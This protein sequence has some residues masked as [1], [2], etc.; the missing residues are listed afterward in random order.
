MFL[1]N[2]LLVDWAA[3]GMGQVH[4]GMDNMLPDID[5][6]P[7]IWSSCGCIIRSSDWL[8]YRASF[9]YSL[10]VI[11]GFFHQI[12][13]D[14]FILLSRIGNKFLPLRFRGNNASCLRQ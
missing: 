13:R 3:L 7:I 4:E 1:N 9:E 5:V 6:S 14:V 8:F 12:L 2:S 10:V 11:R